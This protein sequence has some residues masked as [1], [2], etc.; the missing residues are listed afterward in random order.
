M[1]LLG[2]LF[3]YWYPRPSG[4][5]HCV[6]WRLSFVISYN[7]F[8]VQSW[9]LYRFNRTRKIPNFWKFITFDH[10]CF[11]WNYF[12][13]FFNVVFKSN[14]RDVR[15]MISLVPA[16][17]YAVIPF[18]HWSRVYP[19][20]RHLPDC[21]SEQLLPNR[22]AGIPLIPLANITAKSLDWMKLFIGGGKS[23]IAGRGMITRAKWLSS[24][25]F[26]TEQYLVKCCVIIF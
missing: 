10:E 17:N 8:H 24:K 23:I 21:F 13:S 18:H 6:T 1:I 4:C 16:A 15:L 5:N 14:A 2:N 20:A 26:R 3:R 25:V 7:H 12:K 22:L 9:A 11:N 19:S